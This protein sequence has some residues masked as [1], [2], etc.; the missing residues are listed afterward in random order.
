MDQAPTPLPDLVLWRTDRCHLCEETLAL[1]E[2]LLHQRATAG[3]AVPRLVVRR[4]A[5]DPEAQQALLEQVPVIEVEG[6]RL[7]L[8]VNLGPIRTFVDEAYG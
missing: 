3:Q 6:R 7:L 4:I 8:A 1:V 2:Q 5:E